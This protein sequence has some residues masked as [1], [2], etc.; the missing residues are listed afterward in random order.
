MFNKDELEFLDYFCR[1]A[2]DKPN[3]PFG[4]KFIL[5][6]GDMFQLAPVTGKR[7][8]NYAFCSDLFKETNYFC[9]GFKMEESIRQSGDL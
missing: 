3:L 7:K 2:E 1:E 5:A 6:F 8:E 4:G 9:L